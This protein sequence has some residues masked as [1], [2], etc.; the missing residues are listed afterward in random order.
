MTTSKPPSDA[1]V[2]HFAW[3]NTGGWESQLAVSTSQTP[4]V[5]IRGQASKTWGDWI[6]LL[7]SENCTSV[8]DD[9]YL[10]LTG[11][12]LTGDLSI[13]NTEG[14][15]T[16]FL[17]GNNAS[18]RLFAWSDANYIE[19]GDSAFSNNKNLKITGIGGATGS[20][21]YLNFANIYCRKDNYTN[22]DSGNYTTYTPILN[23]ASTHATKSSVI[24]A[25][26]S[27]GTK[28][29]YLISN[30]SGAPIW[31]NINPYDANLSRTANTVLAAPNGSAGAAT[32]RKLVMADL[33]NITAGSAAD[34]R[35]VLIR[36]GDNKPYCAEGI[37][38][39]ASNK[40]LCPKTTNE[41]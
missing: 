41:G 37:T 13:V 39:S 11:G 2:L 40:A 25:P 6:T 21:L 30:G 10:P 26:T 32:F 24:Y 33:P 38:I 36:G 4:D 7:S 35:P 9:L 28:G 19:S 23:S 15:R 17:T 31:K 1:H 20:N 14:N 5:Y 18:L 34:Y 12:T 27:A 3:D 22:I 16:L 29:Y 8:L